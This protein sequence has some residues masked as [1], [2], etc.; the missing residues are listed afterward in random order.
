MIVADESWQLAHGVGVN[1]FNHSDRQL[2]TALLRVNVGSA[3]EPEHWPGLA[4]LV[5]HMLFTGGVRFRGQQRLMPWIQQQGGQVNATTGLTTTCFYFQCHPERLI[6]GV[7]RLLDMVLQ[8]RLDRALLPREVQIIE[9]EYQLTRLHN[10][11]LLDALVRSQ[12][13][14]PRTFNGFKMGNAAEFG[15]DMQ[16]LGQALQ[17]FYDNSYVPANMQLWLGCARPF[18]QLQQCFRV[19]HEPTLQLERRSANEMPGDRDKNGGMK[20]AKR[21]G[22]LGLNDKQAIILSYSINDEDTNLGS[23]WGLFSQIIEDPAPH[24]LVWQLAEQ[25]N[26]SKFT[27]TLISH[28]QTHLL[29]NIVFQTSSLTEESVHGLSR[30]LQLWFKQAVVLTKQQLLHYHQKYQQHQYQRPLMEQ[31]RNKALNLDIGET[32]RITEGWRSLLTHLIHACPQGYYLL[33]PDV[34]SMTPT[35]F[36]GFTIPFLAAAFPVL[37]NPLIDPKP[38]FYPQPCPTVTI[39]AET[40]AVPAFIDHT[41]VMGVQI[42]LRPAPSTWLTAAMRHRF[43]TACAPIFS[44]LSHYGGQGEWRA[45]QSNDLICL[46]APNQQVMSVV[47]ALLVAEWPKFSVTPPV[48][49][50]S[51]QI[52]IK[53]LLTRLPTLINNNHKVSWIVSIAGVTNTASQLMRQQLASIPV[54]WVTDLAAPLEHDK[55]FYQHQWQSSGENALV[56]FIPFSG[57]QGSEKAASIL[58]GYYAPAFYQWLRE[59]LALGYA[60]S[61]RYQNLCDLQGMLFLLQSPQVSCLKLKRYCQVFVDKMTAVLINPQLITAFG[62]VAE[63][64]GGQAHIENLQN[65]CLRNPFKTTTQMTMHHEVLALHEELLTQLKLGGGYWLSSGIE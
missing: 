12:I 19:S 62:E 22:Y 46:R 48:D 51:E 38:I 55:R 25:H 52:L 14:H 4:H 24:S 1:Y 3:H 16:Q 59:E 53:S 49:V 56:G 2:S 45:Q 35:E 13:M 41:E 17:A 7:L 29:F 60:V 10:T 8:P 39:N 6:P 27:A 32:N 54:Q 9:A 11:T 57:Q 33:D 44:L 47:L 36:A 26:Y 42:L 31:L 50:E 40:I 37:V 28:T 20:L 23:Y 15:Q 63:R 61:C 18:S 5:E 43:I 58:S 30:T 21:S 64:E 65:R 34:P